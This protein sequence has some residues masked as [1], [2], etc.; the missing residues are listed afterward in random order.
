MLEQSW[1]H[2]FVK[3]QYK[4]LVSFKSNS[5]SVTFI[6]PFIHMNLD[7]MGIRGLVLKLWPLLSYYEECMMT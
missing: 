6:L 7:H 1:V 3:I 4:N 5:F 2:V